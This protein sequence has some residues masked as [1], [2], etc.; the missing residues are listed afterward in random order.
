MGVIE[1]DEVRGRHRVVDVKTGE[2]VWPTIRTSAFYPP[3][4]DQAAEVAG[5]MNRAFRAGVYAER[6]ACQ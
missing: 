2:E 3:S 4:D 6:E 5:M 1:R